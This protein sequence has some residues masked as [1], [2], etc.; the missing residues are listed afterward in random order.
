MRENWEKMTKS[1]PENGIVHLMGGA[2]SLDTVALENEVREFFAQH[3]VKQGEMATAQM[4]EQL[5]VNVR[6]RQTESP[7]LTQ[8]LAPAQEAGS[9]AKKEEVTSAPK[10]VM[11]AP[12]V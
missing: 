8:H 7:K 4:L 1:F 10:E 5:G 3:P 6:L 2:E 12:S 9:C 11:A